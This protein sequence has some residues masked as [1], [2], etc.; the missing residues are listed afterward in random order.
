MGQPYEMD[1]E[2]MTPFEN[3]TKLGG[4][5]RRGKEDSSSSGLKHLGEIKI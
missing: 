3:Y 1:E 5:A 2:M 4:L